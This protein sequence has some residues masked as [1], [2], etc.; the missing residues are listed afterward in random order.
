MHKQSR[1]RTTLLTPNENKSFAIG[2]VLLVD[3]WYERLG[4]PGIIG[5][6]KRKGIDLDALVR[7]M[8]AYKLGENFSVFRAGEW[9]GSPAVLEHYELEPFNS[10]ALYRAVELL[11]QQRERIVLELQDAILRLCDLPSTDIVL[12]WTSLVYYGDEPRLAKYGYSRDHQPGERQLTLGVAQLAPPY[13]IPVG[14]TVEAGN[15][16]DSDHFRRTYR[17]VRRVLM[18]GSLLVFDKGANAKVNLVAIEND[19]HDYLTS[20]KLNKCD[21]KVFQSF[22]PRKWQLIDA[23]EGTYAFVQRFPSRVNYYFFSSKLKEDHE[24]SLRRLAERKLEEAKTIQR[25]L[26][27]GKGLPKRFCL[28]NPLVDVSYEYQTKLTRMDEEAAL[29]FLVEEL[30]TGREGYFCLTSNRDMP[31]AEALARYRA[32]DAVE[33]LFH[34]LK[35]EIEVR[36]IRVWSEDAVFGVLLLGFIAQL[37]ICLTRLT[38]EPART[39]ATKFIASSL[40]KLTVTVV[41]TEDGRKRRFYSNFDPMNQAIL[42]T[43]MGES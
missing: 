14:M 5:R 30:R 34:S 1:L 17:Q 15:V 20:K 23:E 13:N 27:G 25:S 37:M 3:D 8:L 18:D 38:V 24:A 6:H 36:P 26:D 41:A 28:R 2:T 4:L 10:R 42:A 43:F 16:N 40:E 22:D 11:G 7:G 33:K 32:K 9:I 12:D 31:P 35:S 21:D 19:G 29:R 39:V